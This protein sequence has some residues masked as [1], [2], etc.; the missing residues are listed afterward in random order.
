MVRRN[1]WF[2]RHFGESSGHLHLPSAPT[3]SPPL[4]PSTQA[5]TA[6]TALGGMEAAH[7]GSSCTCFKNYNTWISQA[8]SHLCLI[9][10]VRGFS[11]SSTFFSC[12]TKLHNIQN[13]GGPVNP[14]HVRS[15]L[16]RRDY[17]H[18]SGNGHTSKTFNAKNRRNSAWWTKVVLCDENGP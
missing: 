11:S 8:P 2:V 7:Q 13:S 10:C 6:F 9:Y 17:V 16:A 1:E 5:S 18:S 4:S 15:C 12:Q 14:A 3:S